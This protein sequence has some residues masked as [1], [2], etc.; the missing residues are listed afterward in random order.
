MLFACCC[1]CLGCGLL[2]FV[3]C[4]VFVVVYYCCLLPLLFVVVV[5]YCCCV[6]G[7]CL[8]VDVCGLLCVA[9]GGLLLFVV[10]CC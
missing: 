2:L 3:D 5:L 1:L 6:V 7:S 4:N 10:D 9:C 8:F